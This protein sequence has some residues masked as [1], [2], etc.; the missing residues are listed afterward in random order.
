MLQCT[1][2]PEKVG[3]Q[4]L[5]TDLEPD[6]AVHSGSQVVLGHCLNGALGFVRIPS[7]IQSLGGDAHLV[8]FLPRPFEVGS[9]G[10]NHRDHRV[11][12]TF[13]VVGNDSL[14]FILCRRE[15]VRPTK[16]RDHRALVRSHGIEPRE[17]HSKDNVD[18]D[19]D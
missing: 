9:T 17:S 6:L 12:V 5:L 7:D 16:G 2:D 10:L 14:R 1:L 4:V 8:H 13:L 18:A 3:I 15:P 11:A 19:P